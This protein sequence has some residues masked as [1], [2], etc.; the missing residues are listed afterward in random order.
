MPRKL[1]NWTGLNFNAYCGRRRKKRK[2]NEFNLYVKKNNFKD[3]IKRLRKILLN[4]SE[5][6]DNWR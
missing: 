6:N 2:G 4:G 5:L 3:G 1:Y